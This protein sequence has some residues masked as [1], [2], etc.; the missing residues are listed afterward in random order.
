MVGRLLRAVR[1]ENEREGK[2]TKHGAG[3]GAEAEADHRR[4]VAQ[5]I[6]YAFRMV[7]LLLD[8]N[9]FLPTPVPTSVLVDSRYRHLEFVYVSDLPN[10]ARPQ[11]PAATCIDYVDRLSAAA[12]LPYLR[13]DPNRTVYSSPSASS[14]SQGGKIQ[15]AVALT[16]SGGQVIP[17]DLTADELSAVYLEHLN[18]FAGQQVSDERL[19]VS[20]E[21]DAHRDAMWQ[22]RSR[23]VRAIRSNP[24]ATREL[25]NLRSSFHPFPL[26]ERRKRVL[27]LVNR[28]DDS[29]HPNP[30]LQRQLADALLYEPHP[31]LLQQSLTMDRNGMVMLTDVDIMSGALD[32]LLQQRGATSR[33]QDYVAA[34]APVPDPST[35]KR[36]K[37]N[38]L[39][40]ADTKNDLAMWDGVVTFNEPSPPSASSSKSKYKYRSN[41]RRQ[42]LLLDVDVYALLYLVQRMTYPV[43]HFTPEMMADAVKNQVI[44]DARAGVTPPLLDGH[45]SIPFRKG[46]PL[47]MPPAALLARI[48]APP[49]TYSGGLYDVAVLATLL[50]L[51][52]WVYRDHGLPP[53]RMLHDPMDTSRNILV[54]RVRN[55]GGLDAILDDK[56][57]VLF[58]LD[59]INK[60]SRS[61]RFQGFSRYES[62]VRKAFERVKIND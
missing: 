31:L 1:T 16:T 28:Y 29:K 38:R 27:D 14:R 11:W 39:T 15:K 57:R 13:I 59:E 6:D 35:L 32:R 58:T 22:V 4:P 48:G 43:M 19:R 7:G 36:H 21:R 53:L 45:R 61:R 2:R 46:K 37:R 51:N 3:A 54:L 60:L 50:G 33:D 40:P 56:R 62:Q 26:D 47:R 55:D 49:P 24:E 18:T 17:L 5:V 12:D 9:L 30:R 44:R 41:M 52:V 34:Y 42:G 25:N 20:R 10:V 23:V 8:N